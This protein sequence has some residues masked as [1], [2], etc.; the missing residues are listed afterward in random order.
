VSFAPTQ[1][2]A[3][4]RVG[5]AID[6]QR[7]RDLQ[8]VIDI[9]AHTAVHIRDP[10]VNADRSA[11]SGD[12]AEYD[13]P[14]SVKRASRFRQSLFSL[15]PGTSRRRTRGLS[16]ASICALPYSQLSTVVKHT[17]KGAR[18]RGKLILW[19]A[20]LSSRYTSALVLLKCSSS[21]C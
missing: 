11:I 9:S 20:Y 10:P 1:P 6:N 13:I 21:P 18:R 4:S 5:L 16:L 7:T 3:A 15:N 12:V 17:L 2:I 19:P 14:R 8:D